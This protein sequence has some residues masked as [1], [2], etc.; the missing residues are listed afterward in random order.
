MSER[1]V[2]SSPGAGALLLL[3][4]IGLA[5]TA[6]LLT[7]SP[8]RV[9]PGAAIAHPAAIAHSPVVSNGEIARH[10][11]RQHPVPPVPTGS[12][13]RSAQRFASGR[14]GLVSF[15][16]VDTESD[17]HGL[18]EHRRYPAASVVKAM[19]LA[20]E[21]RR[22][23]RERAPLDDE[24]A[25]LLR[26]MI[27]YSDNDA[28]DAIYSR[29]G[30]AGLFQVARAAGLDDFTVAGH[31]GN[32]QITAADMA[33][34]FFDL[35]SVL[36]GPQREFGLGLLG[37]IVAEQSWGIPAAAGPDWQVRFKGGWITTDS[38][39]LAHQA[40]ELREGDR[41]LAIAVLTDGQ[42]SMSYATETVRGIAERLLSPTASRGDAGTSSARPGS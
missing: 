13:L 30:D 9:R 11:T 18:A 31:W 36:A 29:V 25:S 5:L 8:R 40:A 6:L 38:G 17:L 19:L 12:A 23:E 22:L 34:L 21:L 28:A 27:T 41:R 1:W 26:A 10:A 39:Q 32:A 3:A 20:A 37:S 33:R 35:D 4:V 14:E 7:P 24:T 42:P 15:A 2:R 16:V